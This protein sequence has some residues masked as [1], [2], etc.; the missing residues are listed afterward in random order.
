[1]HHPIALLLVCDGVFDVLGAKEIFSFTASFTD[2]VPRSP[3]IYKRD[4]KALIFIFQ[5]G[6]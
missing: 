4:V 5:V 6:N 2:C 3:S 1:M